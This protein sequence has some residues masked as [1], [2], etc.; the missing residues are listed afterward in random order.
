[1]TIIAPKL[2]VFILRL[3]KIPKLCLGIQVV[4]DLSERA[5]K[6]IQENLFKA[7]SVDHL[8]K[9]LQKIL[10]AQINYLKPR[11]RAKYAYSEVA[12]TLAAPPPRAQSPLPS[13]SNHTN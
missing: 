10:Q 3:Q 5:V 6:L 8:Q 11:A 7:K 1:M 4:N 2:L 9:F 13:K 12:T